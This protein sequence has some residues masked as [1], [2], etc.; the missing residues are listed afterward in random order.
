MKHR[1]ELTRSRNLIRR[2][3]ESLLGDPMLLHRAMVTVG[4]RGVTGEE[5]NR[6]VLYLGGVTKDLDRPVSVLVKGPSSS[7]KSNLVREVLRLFP[8]E[9]V[10]LRASLSKMAPVHSPEP[11]GGK[12]L[13]VQ[14]YRGSK[15]A[16]YLIR[17]QQSEGIITHEFTTVRGPHRGTGV[18]ERSGVPVVITT[19]TADQV[20][21]DDET[22]FLSI[23]TDESPQQTLAVLEAEIDR[24]TTN[25]APNLKVWHEAMRLVAKRKV[26]FSLPSWFRF[27]AH[28]LP[29][30]QV[31]MR[32]DWVR[33]LIFCKA[34]A[35]LRSFRKDNKSPK[36]VKVC[37]T[38]YCEAYE[39]L[40][41]ALEFSVTGV[42]EREADLKGA[43][44]KLHKRLRRAVAVNEVASELGWKSSHVYKF[45]PRAIRH[46]LLCYE[47]GIRP[48]NQKRLLPVLTP[49]RSLLPSP[50][51]VFEENA[52]IG[53]G[54]R[55][56]AGGI[57][58]LIRSAF[59]N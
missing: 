24:S 4:E 56:K 27:V 1:K 46:G 20:S 47:E 10:I 52:E 43:V 19:T 31:R 57:P 28:R 3:A 2:K 29:R 38:D 33:F 12:I 34:I 37:F 53:W 21:E 42:H 30:G 44:E 26:S 48:N 17:L 13:Y 7:G 14:E 32:R 41:N 5:R 59:R 8:P 6:L 45:I 23:S 36:V 16:Q 22:R 39:I 18:S 50:R 15:D 40:K 9:A 54:F 49:S 58:G 11:L 51:T 55:G 35:L 25:K